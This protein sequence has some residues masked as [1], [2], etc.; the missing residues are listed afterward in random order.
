[1]KD[2]HILKLSLVENAFDYLNCSLE[3]FVRARKLNSQKE[4]KFAILNLTH[5]IELLL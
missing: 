2:Q 5:G 1:M 3:F 4:W